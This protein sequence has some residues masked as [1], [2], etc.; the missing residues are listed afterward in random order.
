MS[1]LRATLE[2]T[3]DG[4]L[5]V[6]SDGHIVDYNRRFC[7]DVEHPRRDPRGRATTRARSPSPCPAAARSRRLPG[8]GQRA[9]LRP[10]AA[11]SHDV[12][13]FLDGR[14]FERDSRPQR[15]GGATVGRVWSFRDVT[16]ERRATRRATFLAAASKLLAGPLEDVTPLDVVARMTVPW[17][18]DWCNILLVDD[19]GTDAQ[20]RRLP[21]RQ[22]QDRAHPPRCAPT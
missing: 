10:D 9:L 12:I 18:C 16:A 4:I 11:I 20:R 14:I 15:V 21:P 1:L 19:D 22:P 7:G 17:L 13:E 6:D 8:E 2:A 5:V 3:T